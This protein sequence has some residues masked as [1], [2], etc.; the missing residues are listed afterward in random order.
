MVKRFFKIAAFFLIIALLILVI[1]EIWCRR[2]YRYDIALVKNPEH[3]PFHKVKNPE[4]RLYHKVKNSEHWLRPYSNAPETNSDG[5]RIRK[6]PGDFKKDDLNI[7]FLGDSYVYGL[8]QYREIAFPSLYEQIATSKNPDCIINVANFGWVSSSPYLSLRFLKDIGKKYS[9]D[10]VFLFVDMTDFHDDLKY[11]R[12]VEKPTL[13]YEK[14][15]TYFPGIIIMAKKIIVRKARKYD[16]AR[17]VHEDLFGIP[18]D[19][20]FI[21]NQPL[22]E[23]KKFTP[24]IEKSIRGIAEYTANE[25]N[26]RFIL[27]IF[28]RSFQYSDRESP[29]SWERH[30]YQ[31]LGPY[32]LEPFVFF[33]QLKEKVDFP[34]YSMLKDFQDSDVF[35]TTLYDDPHWTEK[36]HRLVAEKTYEISKELGIFPC[37][38][39]RD[40][41]SQSL[42][43]GNDIKK[44]RD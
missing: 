38:N 37:E 4:H 31:A 8:K 11:R 9:P 1:T 26:A 13:M 30:L 7:I 3:R 40:P 36:G 19:K 2:V 16:W 24:E 12:L 20:F 14:G 25:L 15:L 5:L 39:K 18:A 34:V 33:D 43:P 32:S 29:M 21:V 42:P 23:S 17:R 10:V 22:E 28:P 35:P 27:V 6:E 41:V 44:N